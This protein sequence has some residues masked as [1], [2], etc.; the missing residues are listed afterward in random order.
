MKKGKSDAWYLFD[1]AKKHVPGRL[2]RGPSCSR[3]RRSAD[4]GEKGK[5]PKGWKIFGVPPKTVVLSCGVG[6]VVCPGVNTQNPT[7]NSYY[8]C[9][10]GTF[11]DVERRAR[12]RR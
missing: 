2:P 7:T 5:L 4:A 12:S 9:R 6:E 1:G 8:L 3:R 11:Q 10:F